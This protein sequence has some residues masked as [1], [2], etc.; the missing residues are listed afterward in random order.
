MAQRYGSVYIFIFRVGAKKKKKKGKKCTFFVLLYLQECFYNTFVIYLLPG[1]VCLRGENSKLILHLKYFCFCLFFDV[2][3][4][5]QASVKNFHMNFHQ[6]FSVCLGSS[7]G[8]RTTSRHSRSGRE[9]LCVFV[10]LGHA[11][12]EVK[13]SVSVGHGCA[14]ERPQLFNCRSLKP[15]R[16]AMPGTVLPSLKI[17]NTRPDTNS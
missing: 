8:S 15:L 17:H 2:N 3:F 14:A 7:G 16:P 10:P 11:S 1:L 9:D 5:F 13:H 4:N 6:S 12:A